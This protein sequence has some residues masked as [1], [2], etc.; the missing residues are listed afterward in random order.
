[1]LKLYRGDSSLIDEFKT[2]KTSEYGLLGT[3]VYLT[4]SLRVAASY[5]TKGSKFPDGGVIFRGEATNRPEAYE[6]A[7]LN[8]TKVYCEVAEGGLNWNKLEDKTFLDRAN[9]AYSRLIDDGVISSKYVSATSSSKIIEVKINRDYFD[10]GFVSTFEFETASFESS[11][12]KIDG[13]NVDKDFLG[14]IYDNKIEYGVGLYLPRE[15][16]IAKNRDRWMNLRDLNHLNEKRHSKRWAKE[17]A[18]SKMKKAVSEYGIFGFEYSG[19]TYIGGYGEHRAFCMWNDEFVNAAKI[20][21]M[22]K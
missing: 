18:L 20:S 9:H 8:F 16:Y 11:V 1:M 19:G 4:T 13:F 14:I 3:G 15:E 6:K 17:A 21:I 5:V 10:K 7:F 22:R 2:K 12:V